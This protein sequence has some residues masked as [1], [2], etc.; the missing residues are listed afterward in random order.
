MLPD[1]LSAESRRDALVVVAL[2][3][4]SLGFYGQAVGFDFV[5][6]DDPQILLAHPDRYDETSFA[7]SLQAIFVS[8]FP[9]EEPLV[10][11]DL[12]WALDAGL[13]G[14][15]NPAGYHAGNVLL[16]ALVVGLLFLFLRRSGL[17]S[18]LAGLVSLAFAVAPIHVEPV[19]WVMGRKDLLA[20]FFMLSGL[21]AQ[22][23]ELE[24]TTRRRRN[25]A[26]SVT[27]LCCAL[28]L[29]SKISAISFFLVLALHRAFWP[30]L[31][32]GPDAIGDD[33]ATVPQLASQDGSP[34]GPFSFSTRVSRAALPV[35]PH[36]VLSIGTFL[37]Y[38][39][40][41]SSYA[42]IGAAHPGPLD[43]EHLRHVF[44]FLPLVI[45][46]YLTHLVWPHDLSVYY[47]WPHVEIPL[48]SAQWLASLAWAVGLLT[49]LGYSL[50]R[51]RDVAFFAGLSIVLLLPYSGFFYVGL[52]HADR[53]FYL[54]SAGVLTIAAVCLRD[55]LR[56]VPVA[57]LP[58]ALV[59][60]AFLASS[61]ALAYQQQDV[62]RDN[63]ALWT[64]EVNRERPSLLAFQALA[65]EYVRRA[66]RT[67]EEAE[68]RKWTALADRVVTLG[69][70]RERELGRVP[71]RYRVP[72]QAQLATLHVLR[73]RLARLLGA[74]PDEQAVH[75]R[76]AFALAP[77]GVSALYA[78]ESLFYA[79]QAASD[80]VQAQRI[81]ESFSYFLRFV[82]YSSHDPARLAECESLL[83]ANYAGRFPDLDDRIAEARRIYFQ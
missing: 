80:E 23:I 16:N 34:A 82:E 56:R 35:V 69:F 54:A 39:D 5:S 83:E 8:D 41:I 27:L 32:T 7:K 53:Y 20:A 70:A 36:A 73:G 76:T 25:L 14:F 13:F 24:S 28:A 49:L 77:Q 50:W 78:S 31:R 47:R 11:R 40:V 74:P 52:W 75:F 29:G 43:P 66:E 55:L 61:A 68:R 38:R 48:S 22:C 65:R 4:F 57:R 64:Y 60:A 63:E 6:F 3:V 9:R 72:E 10:V 44:S 45:G 51:R 46:E 30:F 37:W 19:A 15:A 42:V 17:S 59:V 21:V 26:Y 58:V 71:S 33:A 81:S 12:T 62:W 1:S 2:L 79:A 18:T 67:E